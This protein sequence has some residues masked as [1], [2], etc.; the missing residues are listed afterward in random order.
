MSNLTF[1]EKRKFEQLLGM[2]SGYVSDFSHRTFSE[3]VLD[4]TG[5]DIFDERYNYHSGSK[6]NR[7]RAFWQTEDNG[8][9]G[10]LM[11]DML[12]Y[13]DS[14]GDLNETCRLIVTRLLRD[15]PVPQRNDSH[16]IQESSEARKRSQELEQLKKEFSHLTVEKDRNKA[17]LELERLLNCLFKIFELRP[18]QPFRVVGEQIDGSFELGGQ[19]YL[20]E[21]KWENHPLPG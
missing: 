4:S 3:F 15:S 7:L 18:R 2:D 14:K 6:A 13:C 12:D 8:L 11:G 9:V 19:V 17:G 1:L 16:C 21:S 5:I 10:K 20:L